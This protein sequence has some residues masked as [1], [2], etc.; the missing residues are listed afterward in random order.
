VLA[1]PKLGKL[2]Q[3]NIVKSDKI[4]GRIFIMPLRGEQNLRKLV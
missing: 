1:L 2:S 3:V 4:E